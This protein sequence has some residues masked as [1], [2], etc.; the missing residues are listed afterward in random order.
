MKWTYSCERMNINYL[1]PNEP[2]LSYISW[3][4]QVMLQWDDDEVHFVLDQHAEL[5]VYSANWHNSSRVDIS[6][7]SDILFWFWANQ[8]LPLLLGAVYLA[9]NQQ[10]PML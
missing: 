2:F 5:D 8:S 9:E 6:L 7:N 10:I 3:Q 1:T 4:E